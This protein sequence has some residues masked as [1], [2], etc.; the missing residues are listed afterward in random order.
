MSVAIC[1]DNLV[2]PA[3]IVGCGKGIDS[4]NLVYRC[5]HCDVPFH[6]DCAG[7]H[8]LGG[9]LTDEDIDDMTQEEVDIAY[10]MMKGPQP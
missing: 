8:F 5:T 2:L 1:G 9:V 4:W 10:K 7:K 3:R 6:K